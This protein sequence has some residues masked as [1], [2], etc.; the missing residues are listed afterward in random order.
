MKDLAICV[1]AYNRVET[2]IELLKTIVNQLDDNNRARI[3]ICVSD[4]SSPTNLE[5]P[6]KEFL[7][8]YD[9]EYVFYRNPENLG[10]DRN[11]LKS[12]EIANARYCW[13]MGDDDGI[14]DGKLN[15]ILEYIDKYP[16]INVFFGNRYVCNKELKIKLKEEW[17]QGKEDFLVDF[18]QESEIKKYLNQLNSTTCLGFLSVLIVKKDA[19]DAITEE[20]YLPYIET[21]YIQVAKYLLMLYKKDK[22]Y[23]IADYIALSR[24][25]NDN[26]FGTLKQRIFMDLYGFLQVSHI[27]D[28]NEVLKDS[29]LG[30]VRRHFNNIFLNAMS[31][32][33]DLDES[34]I[35]VLRE[36]GY[37]KKQISIFTK[38]NRLKA[39]YSFGAAVIKAIFTNP[40]WFYRTCFITFQKIK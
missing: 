4:D 10:A 7:A 31:F 26:F 32:T 11:F 24:F 14:P 28:D 12:T 40:R 1:P 34:E 35:G 27:F 9:V 22:L 6:T 20:M 38:R 29:F 18:T 16:E 33:A 30:I 8:D 25:G 17:T 3:Q 13:L 37:T 15:L 5:L 19:W 2:L 23:R 36:I 21:I 39:F